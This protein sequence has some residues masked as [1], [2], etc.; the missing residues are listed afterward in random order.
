MK[1][2]L[3]REKDEFIATVVFAETRGKAR[4]IAQYTDAC[5]D[6]DFCDIEV[7]RLPNMDK[8]YKNGKKE[9]D[10]LNPQ[11]RIIL[12]KECGFQCESVNYAE[13][14]ECSAKEFC[15]L[16]SDYMEELQNEK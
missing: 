7:H 10:W 4:A 1:A 9:M 8:H 6:V 5:E 15:D 14:E 11:D 13:C 16:Y 2:W 12:V 3:V